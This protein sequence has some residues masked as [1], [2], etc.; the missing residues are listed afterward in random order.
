VERA[1]VRHRQAI[2]DLAG[3]NKQWGVLWVGGVGEMTEEWDGL[4]GGRDQ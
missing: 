4:G 2:R 3:I 1:V